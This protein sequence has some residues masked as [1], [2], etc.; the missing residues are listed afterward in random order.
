MI[1]INEKIEISK[2]LQNVIDKIEKEIGTNN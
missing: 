2:E 1:K